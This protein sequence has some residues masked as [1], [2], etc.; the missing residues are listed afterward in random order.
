MRIKWQDRMTNAEVRRR[1][2]IG[3]IKNMM[4]RRRW[5][6]FGHLSRMSTDRLPKPAL[7]YI[8]AGRKRNNGRPKMDWLVS[9]NKQNVVGKRF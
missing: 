9:K 1:A 8:P 5:Q 2:G 4:D 7:D 6:W 3:T